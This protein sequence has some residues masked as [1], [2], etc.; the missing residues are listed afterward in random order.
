MPGTETWGGSFPRPY[1]QLSTGPC[2]LGAARSLLYARA[3]AEPPRTRTEHAIVVWAIGGVVLLL[4]QA[5]WRLLP[6]AL[7][8]L[9]AGEMTTAAIAA[10]LVSV[11]GMAYSEGYR[12]FQRSF[13]P[14]AVVRALELAARRPSPL[15]IALAPLVS[16]GLIYATRRRLIASWTLLIAVV[17]LIIVVAQLDQP[18]RGAVDA[19]VVVGLG[20][21]AIATIALAIRAMRGAV[22][23]VSA[24]LPASATR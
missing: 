18:W 5:V 9:L 24:D 8:P 23:E 21:G 4:L 15:L 19:G 1:G 11:L 7:E 3:M 12:G 17:G 6:R 20:W 22:P 10:Y 13:S 2:Q 14:R 16:M